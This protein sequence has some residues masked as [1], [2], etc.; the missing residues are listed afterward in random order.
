MPSRHLEVPGGRLFVVDEG[1]GPP[2][3]LLHAGVADLR[4]W[5]D[6]VPPLVAA[7]YRAVRFDGRGYGQSTT[8]DV[9]FSPRAEVLA[10]MDALGIGRAVLVG[11]S[12][13][14]ALALDTAIEFP[15]HIVAVVGVASG[16]RG[17]DGGGTPAE[18]QIFEAYEKVD[19]AEPF[20]AAALT[21]FEVGVWGDGPGQPAGRAA[22]SVR[23]RLYEMDLPL[24][25]PAS[26]K[27][28]E[29]PL[30]PPANDRLAELRCPVLMAAGTLDFSD[31][32]KTAEHLVAEVPGARLLVWEDVAHMIGM[33]QPDRLA[34]AIVEFV[35]PLERWK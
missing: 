9:E 33:E 28:R 34:T 15:T 30:D 13:G 23:E 25:D 17:F 27:G 7:G 3:V 19:T 16:V 32:V 5:D 12:R 20:D 26:V 6:V 1:A 10:V 21:E 18:Q 29:I 35:A 4:A 8:E 2:I 31:T 22:A 11:N 14:G 24:N